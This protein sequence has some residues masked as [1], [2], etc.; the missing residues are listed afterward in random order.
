MGVEA[1]IKSIVSQV[2]EHSNPQTLVNAVKG[3]L[4]IAKEVINTGGEIGK[5]LRLHLDHEVDD[6]LEEV[7][8]YM[9]VGEKLAIVSSLR[10]TGKLMY[11]YGMTSVLE[12][13]STI[14]EE[15][16]TD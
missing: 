16:K 13:C 14:E 10:R 11:E 3:I 15:T 7:I 6:A 4:D 9:K 2:S 8:Q 1:A 12:L 5:C